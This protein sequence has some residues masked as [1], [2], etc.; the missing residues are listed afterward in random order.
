[1]NVKLE[2]GRRELNRFCGQG[3]FLCS[4]FI[5]QSRRFMSSGRNLASFF[6]AETSEKSAPSLIF[7]SWRSLNCAFAQYSALTFL[8]HTHGAAGS[9]ELSKAIGQIW[10]IEKK[11][12][13]FW[14]FWAS[15]LFSVHIETLNVS[16]LV[17]FSCLPSSLRMSC[18]K[19]CSSWKWLP[20]SAAHS[21]LWNIVVCSH[22]NTHFSPVF[23]RW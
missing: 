6:S 3:E 16:A 22:F 5:W 23:M 20:E 7:A 19:F 14:I 18:F 12:G 4:F 17:V 21:P 2:L 8:P 1:M 13:I 15:I 11:K 9:G 10:R